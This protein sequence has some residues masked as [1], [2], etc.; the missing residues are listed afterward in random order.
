MWGGTLL[1]IHIVCWSYVS[2]T[3]HIDLDNIIVIQVVFT[4]LYSWNCNIT[5][6]GLTDKGS[7]TPVPPQS[8]ARHISSG[9]KES[10]ELDRG[11]VAIEEL[12]LAFLWSYGGKKRKHC[13]PEKDAVMTW[14]LTHW[15]GK[16]MEFRDG[17]WE[18]GFNKRQLEVRRRVK[19]GGFQ[20]TKK[21]NSTFS[22]MMS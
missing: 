14:V 4:G 13:Y 19:K 8:A 22:N 12:S 3:A 11:I 15:S 18:N 17:F 1:G 6:L 2:W 16:D 10:H 21:N 20:R 9:L 5:F 7:I